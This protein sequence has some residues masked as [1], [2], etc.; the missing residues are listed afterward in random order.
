MKKKYENCTKP[1]EFSK[2]FKAQNGHFSDQNLQIFS[3][4]QLA[5]QLG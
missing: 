5:S 3:T 1:R 2:P 4:P